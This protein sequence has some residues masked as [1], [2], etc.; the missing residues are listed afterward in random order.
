MNFKYF[1]LRQIF[2]RFYETF[3]FINQVPSHRKYRQFMNININQVLRIT[4]LMVM[5]KVKIIL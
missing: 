2:P 4:M 3:Y 5:N 1:T